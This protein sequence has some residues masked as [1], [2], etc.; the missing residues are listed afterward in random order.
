MAG[1]Y[2]YAGLLHK[3]KTGNPTRADTIK[4]RQETKL[5]I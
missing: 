2:Y 1:R 3:Y 4:D 5:S